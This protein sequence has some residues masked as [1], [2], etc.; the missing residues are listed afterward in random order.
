MKA[1]IGKQEAAYLAVK[2][3]REKHND[4]TLKQAIIA[5]AKA[6]KST[7]AS[8][9]AAYYAYARRNNDAIAARKSSKVDRPNKVVTPKTEIQPSSLDLNVLHAT[10]VQAAD[11]IQILKADREKT[12]R[13]M[14]GLRK[15]LL[16]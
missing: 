13:I 15:A 5:V 9:Q 7:A 11:T 12:D 4:V 14:D 1:K 10:L 6:K 8:V 16:V 3:Y 2:S